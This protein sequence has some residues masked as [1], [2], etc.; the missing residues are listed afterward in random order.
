M[1]ASCLEGHELAPVLAGYNTIFS[2]LG[3]LD[4]EILFMQVQVFAQQTGRDTNQILDAFV[5]QLCERVR[6]FKPLYD[7]CSLILLGVVV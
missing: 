6:Q 3:H 2:R 7:W 1:M 5:D 4:G